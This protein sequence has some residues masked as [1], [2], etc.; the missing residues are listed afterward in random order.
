M[1]FEISRFSK[2]KEYKRRKNSF[3][4]KVSNAVKNIT[5]RVDDICQFI[6]HSLYG[7]IVTVRPLFAS[8]SY[9][10]NLRLYVL[11][12][13]HANGKRNF[14]QYKWSIL[15]KSKFYVCSAHFVNPYHFWKKILRMPYKMYGPT[16]PPFGDPGLKV[17][18]VLTLEEM[19]ALDFTV[20]TPLINENSLQF[21][22]PFYTALSERSPAFA[23]DCEMVMV[24]PEQRALTRISII[25]ENYEVLLDVLVKPDKQI[26]DYL[27]K[28][29]GMTPEL[30]EGVTLRLADVQHYLQEILP[31]N[32]ILVGHSIHFDMNALEFYHPYVIDIGFSLNLNE[33][34]ARRTSLRRL[35]DR[36]LG[37]NV[38]EGSEGH[39]S[40]EDAYATMRLFHLKLS[41]G[42]LF[43]CV[44]LGWER[45]EL[46]QSLNRAEAKKE[47]VEESAVDPDVNC[48]N[49]NKSIKMICADANCRCRKLK[50]IFKCQECMCKNRCKDQLL[51]QL[52]AVP[53]KERIATVDSFKF[54]MQKV[55]KAREK[56]FAA[57]QE[58]ESEKWQQ[59]L[60]KSTSLGGV[61]RRRTA[62]YLQGKKHDCMLCS[63]ID[64]KSRRVEHYHVTNEKTRMDYLMSEQFDHALRVNE[65]EIN[66]LKE[67]Q[68]IDQHMCDVMDSFPPQTLFSICFIKGEQ[69][70]FVFALTGQDQPPPSHDKV[71]D[72]DV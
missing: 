62:L 59:Q 68:D 5:V 38:Q 36:L 15:E 30:L 54:A 37:L 39:C 17:P 49:C 71:H 35:C 72:D 64:S 23:I 6:Q 41:E 63:D 46:K 61:F 28:W 57:F 20:P 13:M 8:V 14:F 18:L 48:T 45:E 7:P 10:Q 40:V 44:P 58:A 24:G 4:L 22:L 3:Y 52:E 11:I 53:L 50:K 47:N 69:S 65:C 25:N 51:P 66:S 56:S 32:A 70:Q 27:T 12:L 60:S 9:W 67:Q 43:G 55:M 33:N 29:S 42:G 26:I 19:V 31:P 2:K 21:S 1:S 34:S 16:T